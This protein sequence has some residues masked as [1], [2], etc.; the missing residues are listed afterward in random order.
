[1][2]IEML[3][4]KIHRATVTEADLNYI[5]SLTLDEDLMDAAGLREYEKIGVL[6]ITNGNR[7]ET[8]II[9]G[10][11]GSGKVCIN[12][13]ASHLIS[14]D[15]LVIIVAY[16]QLNET[17]AQIHKPKIVHVNSENQVTF[18]SSEEPVLV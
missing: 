16:C 1:M 9:R 4:G 3:K 15:D 13:A 18:L 6:D 2:F 17:E 8:Y 12:G 14:K 5:G 7:I 11:R 10:E